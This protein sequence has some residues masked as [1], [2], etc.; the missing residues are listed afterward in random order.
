MQIPSGYGEAYAYN[1][2]G[3][4]AKKTI[5]GTVPQE[6]T[7]GYKTDSTQA[8]ETITVNGST[9]KP[10][11]DV[12]GRNKGKA[13]CIGT[14]KIA[15][16]SIVYRKVGD[17][18]TNMPATIRFGNKY[19]ENFALVD[20]LRYA[21]DVMGNIEKV[22][23]NGELAIRYQ[24]DALNR[25]IRED[26]KVMNK[27]VL[28]SYDNNG[29]ILKQRKFTF[30]LKNAIDIEELDSED[31]VYIYDG[32]K[33][34]AFNGE[35]CAYNETTNV[36]TTYRGKILGWTNRRVTSYNG[37][38]FSYDGQGRR[39]AK[40]GIS[41]IYDSQGRLL[42][43]S[44][45]LEFF[46]DHSGVS[47]VKHVEN[48][49]FYRKDIL[50]NVIALLDASGAVVVK[51]TYDA[52]GNNVVSNAN[53]VII[54]DE[55]HIGNVNPFRYRSYYYDADTKLYLF[56]QIVPIEKMAL[57]LAEVPLLVENSTNK[58]TAVQRYLQASKL[59]SA[60]KYM[61][62][63]YFGYKNTKGEG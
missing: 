1:S 50:G 36:Q 13:I 12:L 48:T 54:T 26:N 14:D 55:N 16:E 19:G 27:T 17:H 46:Y 33:L 20:S 8:L 39:I 31:K 40:D 53:N 49:Y 29:N 34:L 58:K 61:L 32:D 3:K 38:Q 18:A 21:Y 23:E 59:T 43:Q 25:L 63:G 28:F 37:V 24:Y 5:V 57:A 11:L 62:M 47:S 10:K 60:Q 22:Y 4:L 44:N 45:D 35:E 41:Y 6:Y 15:E 42:K 51:Y 30:T 9:V 56:G 2:A 7:Y 52:W